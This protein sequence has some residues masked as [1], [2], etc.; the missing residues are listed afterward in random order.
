[1]RFEVPMP[2]PFPGM[3]PY[4]ECA[5][6]W[7]PFHNAFVSSINEEIS[8]GLAEQYGSRIRVRQYETDG[9]QREEYIE[10]FRRD[11]SDRCLTNVELTSPL[12]KT[13]EVGREF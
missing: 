2:S 3:D 1:M 8:A 13:S 4:L 11:S 12:N 5:A 9:P 6:I 7:P 10:I